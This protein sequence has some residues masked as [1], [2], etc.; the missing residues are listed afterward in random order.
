VEHDDTAYKMTKQQNSET[1]HRISRQELEYFERLMVDGINLYRK[2][3]SHE[4][5]FFRFFFFGEIVTPQPESLFQ[6]S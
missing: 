3:T 5:S 6:T 4:V 2:K 1:L